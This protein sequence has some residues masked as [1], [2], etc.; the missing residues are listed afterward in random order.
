MVVIGLHPGEDLPTLPP[1][2]LKSIDDTRGLNVIAT[3]DLTGI[4]I[5][6]PGSDPSVYAYSR[7]TVQRNLYRIPLN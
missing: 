4:A 3:I 1:S 6:A 7:K 2:G 5:F